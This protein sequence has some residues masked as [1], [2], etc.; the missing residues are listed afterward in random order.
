MHLFRFLNRCKV[1]F[2][3]RLFSKIL[4]RVA[5]RNVFYDFNQLFFVVGIFAVFDPA[6]DYIAED[7]TEI[8]VA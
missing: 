6:A 8:F 2:F 3:L 5:E 4:E 7:S 1:S